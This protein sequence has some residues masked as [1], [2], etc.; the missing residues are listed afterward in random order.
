MVVMCV[1]DGGGEEVK[2]IHMS[3]LRRDGTRRTL[4]A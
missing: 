2:E 3:E 4:V 1:G